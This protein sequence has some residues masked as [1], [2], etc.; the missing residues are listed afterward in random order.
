[1]FTFKCSFKPFHIHAMCVNK[2]A[3]LCSVLYKNDCGVLLP[4]AYTHHSSD[5][6]VFASRLK[7]TDKLEGGESI[8]FYIYTEQFMS[9]IN[10]TRMP[11]L[12]LV[13]VECVIC[14]TDT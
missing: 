4:L 14:R 13:T 10:R 7:D 9:V 8:F 3:I 2:T 1:M 6:R 5:P 12:I 11:S